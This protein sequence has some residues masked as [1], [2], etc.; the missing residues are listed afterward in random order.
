[1]KSKYFLKKKKKYIFFE[2]F[3]VNFHYNTFSIFLSSKVKINMLHIL[4][5]FFLY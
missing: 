3:S 1:M 2:D 5:D 4:I